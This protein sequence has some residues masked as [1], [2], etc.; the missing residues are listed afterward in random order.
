MSG[1]ER[2]LF[3]TGAARSGTHL[4]ATLVHEATGCTYLGE[5]N[6]FWRST[7]P[8]LRHDMIPTGDAIPAVADRFFRTFG[9]LASAEGDAAWLLDKTAANSLRLPFLYRLFPD[10]CFVHIIRDGRDVA[11]SVRRKYQGD[12][13]KI[14]KMAEPGQASRPRPSVGAGLAQLR[15]KLA[16]GL[17][18]RRVLTEPRRY[19]AAG[20]RMLGVSARHPW[21]PAVPGLEAMI[22][23][24]STLEVAAYQWRC[25]VEHALSFHAAYPQA[26]YVEIRYEQLLADPEA[27]LAPLWAL[28]KIRTPVSALRTEVVAGGQTHADILSDAEREQIS[29]MAGWT[30]AKL[31]YH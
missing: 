19:L 11:I 27:A 2:C 4:L 5:V 7:A 10:A 13:R 25:C 23:S 8:R 15:G 17:S 21:G 22:R 14:T 31:Q 30:L 9:S 3:V 26:T 28:L 6:D 1:N 16:T 29:G 24:H 18:P 12:T 20:L